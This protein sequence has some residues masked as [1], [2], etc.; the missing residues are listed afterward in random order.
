MRN[1]VQNGNVETALRND[2]GGMCNAEPASNRAERQKF[3][4]KFTI[5]CVRTQGKHGNI[6][7]T[8]KITK[9]VCKTLRVWTKNGIF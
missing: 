8:L 4:R 5:I 2:D 9:P 1:A 3:S 7:S 6:L